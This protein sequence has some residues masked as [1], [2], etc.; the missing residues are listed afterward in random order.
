MAEHPFPDSLVTTVAN[1]RSVDPERLRAVLDDVQ[2]RYERDDGE[3]EYSTR[4]NYG[5]RDEQAYYLY[6]SEN[7][8][9]TVQRDLSVADELTDAARHVHERAMLQS[10][11]GRGTE[12]TVRE[13]FDDG[14]EPLV[15]ANPDGGGPRFGQDV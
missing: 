1:E 3:Y 4:H 11:S 13:M 9:Q 7:V 10:A 5:W 12:R 2:R 8:W 14:N 6:G 15:V